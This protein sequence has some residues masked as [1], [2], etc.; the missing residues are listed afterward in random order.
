MFNILRTGKNFPLKIFFDYLLQFKIP[1]SLS[2]IIHNTH[3][4]LEPS[5]NMAQQY[6]QKRDGIDGFPG[7]QVYRVVQQVAHAKPVAQHQPIFYGTYI[8]TTN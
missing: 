7:P 3:Y 6:N 1:M 5:N 8:Y 2:S 4:H